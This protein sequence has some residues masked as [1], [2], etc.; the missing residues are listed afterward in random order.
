ME[1]DDKKDDNDQQ[2]PPIRVKDL[3]KSF[4]DQQVLKGIGFKVET[5]QTLAVLGRSG[6]GKSV[7][8]K[9]MIGLQAPD[10]GSIYIHGEDIAHL[11]VGPLN[12]V[13]KK[14]GFLFQQG[15]LYDSMSVEENVQFPLNRHTKMSPE[16]RKQRARELLASVGMDQDAGKLP[17]QLSGGMQKRVS[18]ARALALDPD[19]LLF[20][21]PT[22]G[23]D[24]ITAREIGELIL[25]LKEK[26]KIT[27]VVVTHDIHGAKTFSDRL[28][29][30]RD[31]KVA[32]EGTFA[33][34]QKSRDSYVVQFLRDSG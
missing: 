17:A 33:D 28:I 12:E 1:N 22:A 26:Q 16:E 5:G 21:E 3:S 4:G 11:P 15:A 13:R 30:M 24:P 7:L 10:A 8:L 25:S 29:L 20:D 32:I 9:L 23:L 19:I 18:L 27:A 6:M 31:G 14:M 2:G 34:L